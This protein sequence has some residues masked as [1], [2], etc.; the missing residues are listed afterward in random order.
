MALELLLILGERNHSLYGTV[1][2]KNK[3]GEQ[4]ICA[5]SE[6]S[7]PDERLRQFGQQPAHFRFHPVPALG[8]LQRLMSYNTYSHAAFFNPPALESVVLCKPPVKLPER[9]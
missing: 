8:F 5:N 7:Y 3:F 6:R 4:A 1:V 9:G 2:L